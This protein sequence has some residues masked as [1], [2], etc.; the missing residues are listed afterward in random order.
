ME[1]NSQHYL[2][3]AQYLLAS[4]QM[5]DVLPKPSNLLYEYF[6]HTP[7]LTHSQQDWTQNLLKT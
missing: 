3:Q 6:G 1:W 7:L 5:I 4:Y 2:H